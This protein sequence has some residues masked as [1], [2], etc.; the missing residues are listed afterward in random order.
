LFVEAG[1]AD[2][3]VYSEFTFDPV[4]PS[5]TLFTLVGVKP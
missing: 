2:V 3:Q 5:D 4:K 1:F